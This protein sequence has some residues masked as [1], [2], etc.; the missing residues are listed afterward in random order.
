MRAYAAPTAAALVFP[1]FCRGCMTVAKVVCVVDAAAII[2]LIMSNYQFTAVGL[3][4]ITAM[5]LYRLVTW[6]VECTTLDRTES[7]LN[8]IL[9][10]IDAHPGM[11]EQDLK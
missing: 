5:P 1:L 2:A 3:I 11:K 4:I 8:T 10:Q 9:E 6:R 7:T